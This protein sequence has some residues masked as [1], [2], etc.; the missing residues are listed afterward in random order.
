MAT[1]FTELKL[2]CRLIGNVA[3]ITNLRCGANHCPVRP[4]RIQVLT[5]S[6]GVTLGNGLLRAMLYVV[7]EWNRRITY[8]D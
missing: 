8:A 5:K 3:K 4:G 2:F 6:G 7:N 1:A